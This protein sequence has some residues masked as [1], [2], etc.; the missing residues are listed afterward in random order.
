MAGSSQGRWDAVPVQ[1]C[2]PIPPSLFASRS[3]LAKRGHPKNFADLA[4]HDIIGYDTNDLIL[5]GMRNIGIQAERDW[6][7]LRCDNQAIYWELVRAGCGIGFCQTH[8]GRQDPEIEEI[9]MGVAIPPLQLWLT[10]PEKIRHTPRVSCVW[11]H[12]VEQLAKV[13][14]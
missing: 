3:Y 2:S 11:D 9:D 13:V 8:I 10:T 1:P 5:R 6:F 12:L 14:S 4:R 7:C